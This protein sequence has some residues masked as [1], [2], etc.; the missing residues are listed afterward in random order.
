MMN[1]IGEMADVNPVPRPAKEHPRQIFRNRHHY[2]C[3]LCQR[4]GMSPTEVMTNGE[5]LSATVVCGLLSCMEQ[6]LLLIQPAKW[7]STL[8]ATTALEGI[9][10]LLGFSPT[11]ATYHVSRCCYS[12]LYTGE[13]LDISIHSLNSYTLFQ[14]LLDTKLAYSCG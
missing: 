12:Q 9:I 2:I 10:L 4:L 8:L 14:A 3:G 6:Q 13:N 11:A 7:H 1:W 5:I